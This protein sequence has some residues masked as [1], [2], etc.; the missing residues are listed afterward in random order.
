VVVPTDAD[1]PGAIERLAGLEYVH[2]GNLGIEGREAFTTPRSSPSHHLYLCPT[3]SL[4]LAN[5]LAVR[6]YL[7]SH[8]DVAREYSAV[9]K[10]LARQFPHEI[11]RYTDGKTEF[12]LRILEQAGIPA[13]DRD[14]IADANRRL[15]QA[16]SPG[17]A[18]RSAK[19]R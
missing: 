17:S 14:R 2:Q 19:S 18:P 5:H 9:K 11:E 8:P 13:D 4:A 10:S 15:S 3:N 1:V 6:D 16:R 12:L 7:R